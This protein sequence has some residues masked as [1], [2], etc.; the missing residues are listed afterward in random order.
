MKKTGIQNF[1]SLL[2]AS[3]TT[4]AFFT[5]SIYG[6]SAKP[7]ADE[8]AETKGIKEEKLNSSPDQKSQKYSSSDSAEPK[9]FNFTKGF[10]DLAEKTIPCVVNVSTTQILEGREKNTPQFAPGSPLDDIFKDFF[11]HMDKSPRRVQ[12]L[13]TGYIVES[14]SDDKSPYAYIVTNY[15][16][17]ADA[18]KITIV[19]HD[20]TE[21]DAT[22][23]AID[24]RTDV[25]LL[26][27]KTDS[28]P[29]DKRE[30][31]TIK[32][33]DSN[34]IRVGDWCVA[35]GNPFG[36][37]STVTNGVI[38]NRS[39]N[40]GM[41]GGIGNK[42]H[43]GEYVDD[44]IQHSAQ[45]NSGN[46]GGPLFNLDGEVIA[47]NT[48]IFSPSGGNVGIGFAIPSNLVQ[49]TIKQ[50][51]SFGRTKRGW[52]G[53][54]IQ[55]VTDDMAESF[56]FGKERGAVVSSVTPK[57][58]AA[59]AGIEPRDLILEYNGKE[60]NDHNR[61]QRLVGETEVGK[62]VKIKLLR[63][64]KDGK[65]KEIYVDATIAEFETAGDKTVSDTT[66][67][68][69]AVNAEVR[70][71]LGIKLSEITGPLSRQ[72]DL[73]EDMTGAVVVGMSSDSPAVAF[74]KPGDV[75]TEVN[76]TEVMSPDDVAKAVEKE[77][78]LKKKN[79]TFLVNRAGEIVYI[80]VK[81]DD[82]L[83]SESDSD[84]GKN[85]TDATAKDS[86][87]SDANKEDSKEEV[88]EETKPKREKAS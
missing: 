52:L 9:S 88:Q 68:K 7:K 42:A 45:I 25:A 41:R 59:L 43:A 11:E 21:L 35:I 78:A 74:L 57:G 4:C 51:I 77:S 26:E 55:T 61:L 2:L 66:S 34:K 18:K 32:W 38:S 8:A 86:S 37:G 1:R 15:H 27:V 72:Y 29:A 65:N 58:P 67:K 64:D 53:V 36:L 30:L 31:Q 17:I 24:E 69:P 56:G 71:V 81:N 10:A 87:E 16:V 33:G 40:I 22:I 49:E 47:Q 14:H 6:L 79:I 85:K 73:K 82:D 84:K 62:K 23:K 19:L 39:R 75:I 70:E 63:K 13:G 48:A 60:V 12:S 44:F 20:N 80:T 28:L 76:R 54:K 50:L 46:S 83:K 3:I 5:T